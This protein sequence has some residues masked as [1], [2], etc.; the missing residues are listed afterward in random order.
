MSACCN[1][2]VTLLSFID[3]RLGFFKIAN[4][5]ILFLKVHQTWLLGHARLPLTRE[6]VKL[7]ASLES[8][9]TD[10]TAKTPRPLRVEVREI[11]LVPIHGHSRFASLFYLKTGAHIHRHHIRRSLIF[12][13]CSSSCSYP[14]HSFLQLVSPKLS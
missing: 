11:K 12:D 3:F 6:I 4:E 5:L 2:N 10:P 1:S 14:N 9:G 7:F 8:T 13:I